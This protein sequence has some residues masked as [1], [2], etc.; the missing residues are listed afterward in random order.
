MGEFRGA[1]PIAK[2]KLLQNTDIR[3][4]QEYM[5][6]K[7]LEYARNEFKYRQQDKLGKEIL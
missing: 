3:Y 6:L 7:F 5:S 4:R 2:L 1:E